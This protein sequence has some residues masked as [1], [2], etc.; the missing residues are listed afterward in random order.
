MSMPA[1]TR[2]KDLNEKPKLGKRI[3]VIW[4]RIPTP[5]IDA[6]SLRVYNLL[7]LL[8][9]MS[10]RATL[11]ASF[12]SSWS[13][14]SE[15]LEQDTKRMKDI[16]VEVPSDSAATSVENHLRQ[17]GG[18][19][20]IVV[21]GGDYVAAK[22]AASVRTYAPQ[23]IV[24]FDMGDVHYLRHYREAKATGNL[25]ALKRALKSKTREIRG[26][27]QADHTV[28]VSPIEKTL[29]EKDC[30]G[31]SVHVIP[32]IQEPHGCTKPFLERKDVV[33]LGSFQHGPN[34]DA[35]KYLMEEIYPQVRGKIPGVR[36]YI[37]GADPPDFIKRFASSDVIVT[38]HVPDLSP[39]F[40]NCR[41]CLA[42]LRFGSGVKGKVLM[43]MSYGVP[44]VGSSIAAEG[45][46]VVDGRHV[47]VADDANDFCDALVTAYQ[48]EEVWN[49]LS[50][51]GLDIVSEHFSFNA[52][53]GKLTEL[54]TSIEEE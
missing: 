8:G 2:A 51:N 38:G 34:L 43:S 15:H 21:L 30:P 29:L 13:P 18:R 52:V 27:K 50:R 25:R 35:V 49:R 4:A 42:P 54:L 46:H 26:I 28:V 41:V 37:I 17:N 24:L 11:V 7:L 32:I 31:A 10:H 3:L 39:Y 23:A 20:D 5:D 48:D 40:D 44:V 36:C 9:R 22:H 53:R 14:Y 16:G 45:L 12:P 1:L 6:G 47:L 33:F 19:Y